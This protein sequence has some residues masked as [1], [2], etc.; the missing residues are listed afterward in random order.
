MSFN[1]SPILADQIVSPLD[2][3]EIFWIT[4]PTVPTVAG[5]TPAAIAN[6]VQPVNGATLPNVA[7]FATT[8]LS[9]LLLAVSTLG[10]YN[11]GDGGAALYT[12]NG[13]TNPGGG[14]GNGFQDKGG[15]WWKYKV[16][17]DQVNVKQLG[18]KGDGVT[19]DIV[20]IN[21]AYAYFTGASGT[22]IFPGFSYLVNDTIKIGVTNG[23]DVTSEISTRAAGTTADFSVIKYAGPNDRPAVQ[24][25]KN[26]YGTMVNI[27]IV[28]Q[29]G[30]TGTSTGLA[31]GGYG[32]GDS[33]NSSLGNYF[34][35]V[36]INSFHVG[37]QNGANFGCASECTFTQCGG[38]LNDVFYTQSDFNALNMWFFNTALSNCAIGFTNG[39][40]ENLFV[41]GGSSTQNGI[42]FQV[43]ANSTCFVVQGWRSEV[44]SIANVSGLNGG[45]IQLYACQFKDNAGGAPSVTGSLTH[46]VIRDSYLAGS[47]GVPSGPLQTIEIVNC[48]L[49]NWP[50]AQHVPMFNVLDSAIPVECIFKN[51]VDLNGN[52]ILWDYEGNFVSGDFLGSGSASVL[53]YEPCILEVVDSA[54]IDGASTPQHLG[55]KYLSLSHCRGLSE[56]SIPGSGVGLTAAAPAPPQNLRIQGTFAG[57]GSLTINFTR[58]FTVNGHTYGMTS[59][60]FVPT[61][62]GKAIKIPGQGNAGHADWYG[63][64]GAVTSA[65]VAAAVPAGQQAAKGLPNGTSVTIGS[66]EPDGSYFVLVTG[67]ANETF[68]VDQTAN[69][70]TGFTVHSSNASSTATV[71][72]FLFR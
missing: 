9:V 23:T 10:Y 50:T 7:A 45:N 13:T 61:D 63:Y 55:V 32:S 31:L 58:S 16:V 21:A 27:T 26:K 36:N 60:S 18:A 5:T 41:I 46:V 49:G 37:I 71:M 12:N 69:T 15:T 64:I 8:M 53:L 54:R 57:S 43:Q 29:N 14:V 19:N 65:T 3:D 39:A 25:L 48:T 11:P 33:G 56:G 24:Y 66:N 38:I 20:P 51:N 28:N 42:D 1:P 35:R 2:G 6:F 4:D 59:G 72:C 52:A 17:N 40:A 62:Y 30:S 22:V 44:P 67:N 47:I 70:S 68:W 34:V